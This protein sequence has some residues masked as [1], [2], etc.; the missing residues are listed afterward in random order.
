MSVQ[1][2]DGEFKI[3]LEAVDAWIQGDSG[4]EILCDIVGIMLCDKN[5]AEAKKKLEESRANASAERKADKERRTLQAIRIK[6][7]LLEMRDASAASA[8]LGS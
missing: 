3:L 4:G 6:A 2:S 8:L 1:F 5:D 7:K